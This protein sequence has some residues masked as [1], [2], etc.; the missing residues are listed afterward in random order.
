MSREER[1]RYIVEG[2]ADEI[3]SINKPN[4]EA[5]ECARIFNTI[6]CENCGEGVPEHRIRLSVGKKF[7]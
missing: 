3:F 5:P 1:Q 4:F 7:V 6:I 2:P